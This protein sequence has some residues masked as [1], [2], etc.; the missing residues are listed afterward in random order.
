MHWS[1]KRLRPCNEVKTSVLLSRSGFS[2]GKK[3]E[4][5]QLMQTLGKLFA[6]ERP[7]AGGALINAAKNQVQD[8]LNARKADLEQAAL[9]AKL[10]AERI[11][12]TLPGRGEASGGLHPVTRTLERVEQF[13]S[14]IG[15]SVAEGPEV[16][17]D[18]H[19][20]EALNIPVASLRRVRCT[21]RF[22]SMPTCCCVRTL[23]PCRCAPWN[24]GSRRFV[25]SVR[26]SLSL[27]LRYHS[28]ADVPSGR[29]PVDRR[30]CQFRGSQGHHRGVSSG[31]L[32]ETAG[33]RFRP[34]FFPFTEPSAEVDMQCVMCSG[35][36]CRV[37][38]QTGWLEIMGC[39]MVHPNVLR[40]SGIDPER[41]SGFAFGMGA[42]NASP[43]CVTASMTCACSSTMTC[44]F[45]RNFAS[46]AARQRIF[47][48]TG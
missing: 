19:N 32:R 7:Q 13:F 16:E 38:K 36:G 15:Y 48:R 46:A 6:E 25:S 20:F 47:R 2:T 40:M 5:T 21:T 31:V 18:Y 26:A 22:I 12:V 10:A 9:G 30:G 37:C 27:R 44:G 4:L 35:K 29:G 28:F 45:S 24:R 8:V 33:V 11:D 34:S 17:D 1:R 23:R 14:H 42:S 41:Y 43:C 39:G 3:G